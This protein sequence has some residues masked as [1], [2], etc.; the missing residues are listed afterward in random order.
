MWV[1]SHANTCAHTTEISMSLNWSN[2]L[3]RWGHTSQP[4][5]MG[6]ESGTLPW[7]NQL[8]VLFSFPPPTC[9]LFQFP[10]APFHSFWNTISWVTHNPQKRKWLPV[11][12]VCQSVSFFPLKLLSVYLL[13]LSATPLCATH[14]FTKCTIPGEIPQPP[15]LCPWLCLCLHWTGVSPVYGHLWSFSLWKGCSW[16]KSRVRAWVYL[17]MC[18]NVLLRV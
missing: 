2:P 8:V 15:S 3:L 13:S 16:V 14:S 6:L 7:A 18:V 12:G 10:Q 5:T 4:I 1:F 11:V 17:G 9:S